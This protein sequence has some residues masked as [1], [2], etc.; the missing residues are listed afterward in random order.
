MRSIGWIG[1]TM[2]SLTPRAHQ[3]AE[4]GDVVDR[5]DDDDLGAFFDHL[6]EAIQAV[7][8]VLGLAAACRG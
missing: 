1:G 3:L 7:Q 6:R 4:E 5:A 8:H 2:Y